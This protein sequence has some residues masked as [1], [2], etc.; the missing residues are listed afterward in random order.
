[1]IIPKEEDEIRKMRKAGKIV[2]EFF[3]KVEKIIRAGVSTDEIEKLAW[4]VTSKRGGYPSFYGYQRYPAAV[5]VSINSEVIHGI[6]HR[7]KII[8]EGDVVSIDFGVR[9]DGFHA[10]AA[11]TFLVGENPDKK[12]KMLVE[13]T[14]KILYEAISYLKPGMKTGDLGSFIENYAKRYGLSVIREFCGHGIGR[15]LHEDPPILNYGEPNKGIRLVENLTICI[16][17]MICTGSGEVTILSDGWTVV[18]KDGSLSAHFE[19]TIRIKEDGNEIL[20]I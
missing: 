16:E 10:D 5:C 8:K 17:P 20:T 4:D 18:T 1:M 7:N 11:K 3:E 2:A 15:N 13:I 19:H 9:Y 12:A 6:P 14:E